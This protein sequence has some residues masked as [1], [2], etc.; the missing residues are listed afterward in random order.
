[1]TAAPMTAADTRRFL[2]EEIRVAANIRS[3]RVVDAIAS[4][5]RDRF[6]PPGPWIIRGM[7]DVFGPPRQTDDADPRHVH[8]DVSVAI[9]PSRQLYNG[10]P[11]LVAR[12]LAEAEVDEGQRV[13]HIGTGT[14]YFTAL[15]AHVVGPTGYVQG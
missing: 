4:V 7:A 12:W 14:G 11:S 3:P 10:Q 5:P 1:M 8:H 6:L 15:V 13:V 9:D 2:A